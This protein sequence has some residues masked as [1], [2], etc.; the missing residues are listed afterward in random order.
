MDIL[1]NLT[2]ML[3]QGAASGGAAP[4][5]GGA[6]GLGGLFDPNTLG[7]L[8]GSLMGGKGGSGAKSAGPDLGGML[9]SL[10]GGSGGK[11]G[12]ADILGSLMG[13]ADQ[14][15]PPAPKASEPTL[16]NRSINLLRA[17]IYAVKADGKIDAAEEQAINE[18]VRKLNLGADAQAM[19]DKFL[20]EPLN[21]SAIAQNI[22]S[23]DEAL[24]IYALSCAITQMDNPAERQYLDSL[25]NA[26]QIPM[27]VRQE[28]VRRIL[29]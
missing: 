15:P 3:G 19:V 1:S 7:G 14:P 2:K 10:L 22:T 9:G 16:E 8:V 11:G 13:G 21:P 5:G 12:M 26:M 24:N 4:Q 28:L 17:L 20:S 6:G 18:E 29:G 27:P 23:A 25:A